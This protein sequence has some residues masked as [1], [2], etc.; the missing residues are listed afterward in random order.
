M[1]HIHRIQAEANAAVVELAGLAAERLTDV[2]PAQHFPP[3]ELSYVDE[4][5]RQ[6]LDSTQALVE[7]SVLQVSRRRGQLVANSRRFLRQPRVDA[8]G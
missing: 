8:I 5:A 1:L 6:T 2:I 7:S 4:R 3:V